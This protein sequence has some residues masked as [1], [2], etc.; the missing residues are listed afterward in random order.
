MYY[1]PFFNTEATMLWCRGQKQRFDEWMVPGIIAQMVV[2]FCH[3]HKTK[4]AQLINPLNQTF[5]FGRFS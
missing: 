3:L 1:A 4:L 5:H 2:L